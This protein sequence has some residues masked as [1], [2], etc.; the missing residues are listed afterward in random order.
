MTIDYTNSSIMIGT[1]IPKLLYTYY[2][3]IR[4]T[5]AFSPFITGSILFKLQ[6]IRSCLD[7]N[8]T[9]ANAVLDEFFINGDENQLT[10]YVFPSFNF[11]YS[12]C[13]Y[14]HEIIFNSAEVS[15]NY[16]NSSNPL[17]ILINSTEIY[18]TITFEITLIA[19]YTINDY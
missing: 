18:E 13:A 17:K 9:P 14:F 10:D 4:K 6:S 19:K 11:D 3:R 5:V 12:E 15:V 8:I 16:D 7:G 1:L 2:I